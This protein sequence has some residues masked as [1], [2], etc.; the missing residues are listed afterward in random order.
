MYLLFEGFSKFAESDLGFVDNAKFC[1]VVA[2]V[3]A[4]P[5]DPPVDEESD[6]EPVLHEQPAPG[7]L[8]RRRGA[9]RRLRTA[10]AARAQ[11]SAASGKLLV[12]YVPVIYC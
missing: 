4:G 3:V 12:L 11:H 5:R 8:P 9:A 2:C 6:G 7:R 1:C 10:P